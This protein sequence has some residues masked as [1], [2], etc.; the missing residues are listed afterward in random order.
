M[1]SQ[2]LMKSK[3]TAMNAL[4]K[5]VE[6]FDN[7]KLDS[8]IVSKDEIKEAYENVTSDQIRT[9][10]YMKSKLEKSEQSIINNLKNI[11]IDSDGYKDK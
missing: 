5:F 10:K 7:V 9:I 6:K 1:Q 4:L 3:K 11:K 2:L 8:L